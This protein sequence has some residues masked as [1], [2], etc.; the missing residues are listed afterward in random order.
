VTPLEI[1][2]IAFAVLN[3]ITYYLWWNKPLNVKD[4]IPVHKELAIQ[5]DDND[6]DGERFEEEAKSDSVLMGTIKPSRSVEHLANSSARDR[7]LMGPVM[8]LEYITSGTDTM[9][10]G[11]K[12]VPKFYVGNLLQREHS[13]SAFFGCSVAVAFGGI[14]C[15]G[16]SSP[17]Q[18]RIE[19]LL[20]RWS[21]VALVFFPVFFGLSLMSHIADWSTE[22][23][24]QPGIKHWG[25]RFV[26]IV[27]VLAAAVYALA[28]LALLVVAFISL[29]SLPPEAYRVVQ[30]ANFIPHI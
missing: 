28:R 3:I 15:I 8:L 23:R 4:P 22:M 5:D 6:N 2:T 24:K 25:G 1:V 20:W 21:A 19:Q 10:A 17:F 12:K 11:A 7:I 16:W 9:K 18:T 14:H 26:L 29:R 13:R 30:W 27:Y